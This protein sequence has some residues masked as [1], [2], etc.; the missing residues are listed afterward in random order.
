MKKLMLFLII[1]SAF[2]G[3]GKQQDGAKNEGTTTSTV[4]ETKT[5]TTQANAD[6]TQQNEWGEDGINSKTGT[7]FNEAGDTKYLKI[8]ELDNIF[9]DKSSDKTFSEMGVIET[10]KDK[11]EVVW[12]TFYGNGFATSKYEE[13][14]K[15]IND[16]KGDTE[17]I[18]TFD[19]SFDSNPV[20]LDVL[21][22][23]KQG[24]KPQGVLTF[25]F[26][27]KEMI[28]K[29]DDIT[30]KVGNET[31]TLKDNHIM[32]SKG[33]ENGSSIVCDSIA[34]ELSPEVFAKLSKLKNND[35]ISI[36]FKADGKDLVYEYTYQAETNKLYAPLMKYNQLNK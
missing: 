9:K 23:D 20:Y 12:R 4:A 2:A 26:F 32:A 15:L 1:A 10:S 29:V 14:Q 33:F 3:C 16:K 6:N 7:M 11:K 17:A 27:T 31:I 13:L 5:E 24:Q 25:T 36:T 30:L 18:K 22:V 8:T 34:S 35:K 19:S 21:V 28:K